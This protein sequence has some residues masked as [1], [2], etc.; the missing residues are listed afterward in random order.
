M[1]LYG[2]WS[3][4]AEQ[5][6]GDM[7]VLSFNDGLMQWHAVPARGHAMEPR[8]WHSVCVYNDQML[9]YGDK[10]E[11]SQSMQNK[12]MIFV[13]DFISRT[14]HTQHCSGAPSHVRDVCPTWLCA[15]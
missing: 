6:L 5:S 1:W 15:L 2:G 11:C 9:L 4:S 13:F 8:A 10:G 12:R 3:E 7:H 14:W